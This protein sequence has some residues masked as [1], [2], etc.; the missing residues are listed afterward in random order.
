MAQRDPASVIRQINPA[1]FGVLLIVLVVLFLG[2]RVVTH[3]QPEAPE[4]I[5]QKFIELSRNEKTQIEASQYV[6]QGGGDAQPTPNDPGKMK[7]FVPH[8]EL[9]NLT[10]QDLPMSTITYQPGQINGTNATVPMN[11]RVGTYSCTI[12]VS[13]VLEDGGWKIDLTRT[14]AEIM[15]L[16]EALN[17]A[18]ARATT[19]GQGGLGDA[20]KPVGQ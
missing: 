1:L 16:E 19:T 2:R 15:K 13:L 20:R 6:Y 10:P 8:M 7:Y 14:N 17:A 12:P 4:L 9:G 3:F 18:S 11:V 5:I